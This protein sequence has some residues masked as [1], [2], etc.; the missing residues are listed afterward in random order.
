MLQPQVEALSDKQIKHLRDTFMLFDKDQ[1]GIITTDEINTILTSMGK[2][3]T[4]KSIKQIIEPFDID[5]KQLTQRLF[6][7]NYL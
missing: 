5:G 2:D 4:D 1:D 7:C 3:L 6:F